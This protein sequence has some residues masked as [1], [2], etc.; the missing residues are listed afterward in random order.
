MGESN[1]GFM[2]YRMAC[3]SADLIAGI[4]SLA[5][6]TFLDPSR[7]APSEPV[8]ILHIQETADPTVAYAGGAVTITGQAWVANTPAFPGALQTAQIWAAYIGAHDPVTDG[9]PS[10]HLDLDSPGLDTIVTR[11]TNS[12]RGG[13]LELWTIT[14][15]NH[16]PTL[17]S[18]S[19]SSELARR[20]SDWLLAHPKP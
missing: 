1:G 12:P 3:K 15:S 18:G 5:G 2:V 20:L 11:F 10:M 4:A 16:P 6:E 8:N 7:C 14:G 17:Y 19:S 13:A 9:A